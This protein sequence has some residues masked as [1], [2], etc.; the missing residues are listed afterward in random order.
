MSNGFLNELNSL[1]IYLF[2]CLYYMTSLFRQVFLDLQPK[3]YKGGIGQT[4]NRNCEEVNDL[5]TTNGF[6]WALRQI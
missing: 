1:L 4:L 5:C 6:L 2:T 3:G